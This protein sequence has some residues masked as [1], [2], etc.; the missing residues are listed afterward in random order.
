MPTEDTSLPAIDAYYE[1]F[2][3]AYVAYGGEAGAWHFGLWGDGDV[4]TREAALAASNR[5]LCAGLG[6][7]PGMRVL[8]AGCGCGGLAVYLARAFG[9]EVVGVTACASHVALCERNAAAQGVG[10]LTT[11][12]RMDFNALELPGGH[13]D[14]VF[15]QETFTYVTDLRRHLAGV[16]RVLKPGGRLRVMDGFRGEAPLDARGESLHRD[17]QRGWRIGPMATLA[18]LREALAAEGFDGVT[19]RDLAA[20]V[21]PSAREVLAADGARELLRALGRMAPEA[22]P[23]VAA[24]N[25]AA[26]GFCRCVLEGTFD[27]ALV[28]AARPAEA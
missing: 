23:E 18:A 11:F 3:D 7:R 2:T 15:H 17:M 24:H 14:A 20:R 16:R 9:V 12:R 28:E 25:A 26:T 1:R 19:V 27:Y 4:A 21:A 22:D 13:F 10:H 8:D 5:A 6:L